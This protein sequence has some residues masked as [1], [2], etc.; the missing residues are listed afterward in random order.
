MLVGYAPGD[1]FIYTFMLTCSRG[2]LNLANC[3]INSSVYESIFTPGVVC[4]INVL[5]TDDNIGNLVLVGGETVNFSFSAPGGTVA[6]YTFTLNSIEDNKSLGTLKAK[7]YTLRCVSIESLHSQANYIQKNYNTLISSIVSDIHTTFLKSSQPL[8][9]EATNGVQNIQINNQ[10][11]FTAI[12]MVRRR[13]TSSTNSASNYLYFA[14]KDGFQFVTIDSLLKQGPIKYFKHSDAV[15][16]SIFNLTDNNIIHFEIQKQGDAISRIKMGGLNQQVATYD[17]RTRLYTS[18]AKDMSSMGNMNSSTFKS[19]FGGS[20]GLF[21]FIPQLSK[22][23]QTGIDTA[24]PPQ[25][26]SVGNLMQI[27]LKIKV[28]GDCI[29]KAGDTVYLNIPQNAATTGPTINDPLIS[30]SFLVSRIHRAIGTSIDRPRFVDY[31]ECISGTLG[32]G[33]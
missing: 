19:L 20:A 17:I 11:P 26:A 7:A 14:N 5:D 10:K 3:F 29:V 32:T 8:K 27:S 15:G 31:I 1:V 12:D 2:T 25:T 33:A 9:T 30:G 6:T 22:T 23:P 21:S 13:A 24:T 18:I 28:N 4:D 16:S